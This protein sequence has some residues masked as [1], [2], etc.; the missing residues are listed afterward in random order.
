M[1]ELISRT[2]H[3][4]LVEHLDTIPAIRHVLDVSFPTASKQIDQMIAAQ[5]IEE[6]PLEL[7]RGGRPAKRYRYRADHFH[8][9]ALYLERTYLQYR[10]HDVGGHLIATDRLNFDS[11]DHGSHLL[12]TLSTLLDDHPDVQTLAI[13]VAGAV[14]ATGT[15]LFAPDYP[16]LDGRPL[17]QELTERFG[18]PVVIE[19]DMNAAVRAQAS[20]NETT[21]Y[22]YLGTNGPGAGVAVSGHVIRGAHHFAGEISFIPFDDKRNVGQVLATTTPHSDDWYEALSRIILSF[23]VTLNPDAILF[24]SSDVSDDGLARLTER[25]AKRFPLDKLP[26]LRQG[27]WETDYLDGLMQ[28]SIQSFIEQ[29]P[30][31]GLAR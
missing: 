24:T 8:G 29:I 16:T 30:L 6:T 12:K 1:T 2:R 17:Q 28:L 10:I 21:V 19:N 15:I 14:D 31:G 3:A 11:T 4:F 13:G 27:D 18:R 25:C 7:V 20:D 23:S 5:E 9:L 22:V 26:Q